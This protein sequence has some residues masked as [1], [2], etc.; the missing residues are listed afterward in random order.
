MCKRVFAAGPPPTA[1]T[2]WP[3]TLIALWGLSEIV[4]LVVIS[5]DRALNVAVVWP[6]RLAGGV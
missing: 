4:A 5:P 2:T 3:R 6:V 1:K